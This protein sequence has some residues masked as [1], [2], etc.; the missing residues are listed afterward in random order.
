M[1]FNSGIEREEFIMWNRRQQHAPFKSTDSLIGHGGTL[2]GKVQCDLRIEGTFSGEIICSGTVTVGE[3]GMVRST[4][5]AEE[6]VIAGKVFGNITADRRLVMTGT[7]QVHGNISAGALSVMEGSVL[8]GSVDMKE[9]P[10]PDKADGHETG[11]NTDKATKWSS[12]TQGS[13]E[14][15]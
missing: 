12:Q 7:G 4:I 10:A 11:D 8:N 15:G 9:Q 3:Q 1:K 2:E 13:Q 14:A 6:I 5:R